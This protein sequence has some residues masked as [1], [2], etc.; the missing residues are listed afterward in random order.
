MVRFMVS[1][2]AMVRVSAGVRV[3]AIDRLKV[4]ARTRPMVT[5]RVSGRSSVIGSDRVSVLFTVKF[6]VR[7]WLRVRA[8][9]IF[10]LALGPGLMLVLGS[11]LVLGLGIGFGLGLG[12]GLSLV[13]GLGLVLALG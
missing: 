9:V 12:L 7:T 5:F 10:T 4:K 6:W 13:L 3:G 2:R 8:R 1:F 11:A